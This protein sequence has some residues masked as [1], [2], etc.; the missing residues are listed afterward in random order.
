MDDALLIV[1]LP[2]GTRSVEELADEHENWERRT[3]A[4]KGNATF[5]ERTP[6]EEHVRQL[7]RLAT[8][9]KYSNPDEAVSS[10]SRQRVLAQLIGNDC[11]QAIEWWLRLPLFLQEAGRF[12]EAMKEFEALRAAPPVCRGDTSHLKSRDDLNM[13]LHAEFSVIYDKM[14][15]ACNREGL[16]ERETEY[17][18]LSEGHSK[19]WAQLNERL[20]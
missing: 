9:I 14:R 8:K 12:D 17:R 6:A 16:K 1:E 7:G 15:L 20:R 19:A 5:Y 18:L 2:D 13:L 11:G 3:T 4:V 10:L